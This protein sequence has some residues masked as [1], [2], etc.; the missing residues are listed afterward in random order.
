MPELLALLPLVEL[1]DGAVP[2]RPA[3]L[4]RHLQVAGAVLRVLVVARQV[5]G[6]G[7]RAPRG[8]AA[9]PRKGLVVFWEGQVLAGT[10]ARE[11]LLRGQAGGKGEDRSGDPQGVCGATPQSRALRESC[12]NP[13]EQ[14]TQTA[15]TSV[16]SSRSRALLNHLLQANLQGQPPHQADLA[17]PLPVQHN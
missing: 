5:A 13:K 9:A 3:L 15:G 2:V 14:S 6:R 4:A 11:G 8:V 16:T 12:R 1:P 10:L 17:A 7:R